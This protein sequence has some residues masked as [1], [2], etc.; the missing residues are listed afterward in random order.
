[1][2]SMPTAGNFRDLTGQDFDRLHVV[3]FVGRKDGRA[4]WFCECACGNKVERTSTQLNSGVRSCGCLRAETAKERLQT[5]GQSRSPLYGRYRGMIR[6][7]YDEAYKAYPN[8]G[9]RGIR[10][11]SRWLGPHGFT[12]FATDMGDPAAGMTLERKDNDGPYSPDNCIW[13]TRAMQR[14]NNRHL[15]IVE[16]AGRR[17]CLKDWVKELGLKYT[18]VL[19][20]MRRG[21]TAQEAIN[22][23]H[24]L[25]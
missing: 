3:R 22:K 24:K 25:R 19:A 11:C 8:Y 1:M 12:N 4:L 9:G 23:G 13:A 6:R 14:R 20:R 15:I 21:D 2:L 16:I 5:H 10:I 7:C 18:T 17:Q